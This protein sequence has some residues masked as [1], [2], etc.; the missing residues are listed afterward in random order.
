MGAA[1]VIHRTMWEIRWFG[2]WREVGEVVAQDRA[3]TLTLGDGI[4]EALRLLGVA[5]RL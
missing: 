5:R 1:K 3:L 4:I 2:T